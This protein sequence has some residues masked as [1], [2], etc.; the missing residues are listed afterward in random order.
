MQGEG[1]RM[2]ISIRKMKKEDIPLKV[3]WINDEQNN[4]F[5]HY[6]LPLEQSKTEVWYEKIKDRLDRYD[7]IIEADGNPVGVI[8]ILEIKE[9][10]GEY[11][12]TLGEP[13]YKGKG[14]ATEATRQILQFAFTELGL[15]K[16]YL[17]T[18][19]ENI[20]AQKLFEKAGFRKAGTEYGK[21]K[22]RGRSVDRFYYEIS[23]KE[24]EEYGY[25]KL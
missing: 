15:D 17:Y 23:R 12:I 18:E 9:N 4:Q 20:P 11:Y 25:S 2:R 19:C 22:N 16:V 13:S 6:D 1:K 14:I 8:G 7:G 3:K 21:V 10:Q 24:F 5:L